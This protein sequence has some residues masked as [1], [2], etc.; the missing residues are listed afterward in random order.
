MKKLLV[1]GA[2]ATAAAVSAN[3]QYFSAKN[4]GLSPAQPVLG[5][6]GN[7]AP[8]GT[9]GVDV[10]WNGNIIKSGTLAIAGTFALGNLTLTGGGATENVTFQFWDTKAGATY[11]A[12]LGT[13]ATATETISVAL[14]VAPA[15]PGGIPNFKSVQLT[16]P[17][18][19][20]EPST[21]ALGALGLGGLLLVS[22]RRK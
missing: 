15:P 6:D 9:T 16:A 13:G 17:V 4:L 1:I 19:G 14:A 3:A 10:V 20:P 22:R 5:V 7:P 12:A 11:A 8:A 18:V 21:Y 2:V